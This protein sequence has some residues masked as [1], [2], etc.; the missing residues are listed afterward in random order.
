[1]CHVFSPALCLA[2]LRRSVLGVWRCS[3]RVIRQLVLEAGGLPSVLI[4]YVVTAVAVGTSV[5][6]M[7]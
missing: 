6:R 5:T 1:M 4:G 2:Q 3:E 7:L